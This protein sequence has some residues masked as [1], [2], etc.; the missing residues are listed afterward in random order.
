MVSLAVPSGLT[1]SRKVF[2]MLVEAILVTDKNGYGQTYAATIN[3][4][5]VLLSIRVKNNM[6]LSIGDAY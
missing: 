1:C 6:C 3:D 4:T 5:N 2:T